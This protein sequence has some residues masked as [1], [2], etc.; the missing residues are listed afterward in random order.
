MGIAHGFFARRLPLEIRDGGEPDPG[1]LGYP[2][3][4]Q[5]VGSAIASGRATLIELQTVYGLEDLYDLLEIGRIEGYNE[6]LAHEAA[7]NRDDG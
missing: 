4:P 1:Y 7:A 2:N 6:R 5:T 3:V